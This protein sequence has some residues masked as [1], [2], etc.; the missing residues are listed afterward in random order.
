MHGASNRD[1]HFYL[2]HNNPSVFLTTTTYVRC[3]GWITNGMRSGWTT[4]QDSSSSFQTLVP[5][6][7]EWP[8]QEE[9][10]SDLTASVLVLGVSTPA[11]TNG[12]WPPL[13]PVSVA[14]KNKPSTMLSSNVQSIDLMDYT[15]WQFWTI[16]QLNGC[17][18][19]GPKSSTAKQWIEELAQKKKYNLFGAVLNYL[20]NLALSICCV[21]ES[22]LFISSIQLCLILSTS[23]MLHFIYIAT[24]WC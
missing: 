11:C 24:A 1:T 12:V 19:P 10:W 14:Q 17:S 20:F 2:P 5:A 21:A 23:N 16:R 13:R 4:P 8:S 15:A 3:P 9:P 22:I 7:L 6:L 18:T